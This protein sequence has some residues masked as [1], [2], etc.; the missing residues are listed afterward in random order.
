MASDLP[1]RVPATHEC[2]WW[3]RETRKPRAGT[4]WEML[5]MQWQFRIFCSL[6]IPT[7]GSHLEF[8]WWDSPRRTMN[9]LHSPWRHSTWT[10][11]DLG[12]VWRLRLPWCPQQEENKR[13]ITL[14]WTILLSWG[15]DMTQYYH[16]ILFL[17]HPHLELFSFSLFTIDVIKLSFHRLFSTLIFPRKIKRDSDWNI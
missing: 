14:I 11:F 2:K 8:V 12:L 15:K 4:Y 6:D 7:R 13:E 5:S 16:N 10:W 9:R 17:F 1:Q 3:R